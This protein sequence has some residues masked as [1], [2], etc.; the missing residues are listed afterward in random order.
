MA[1]FHVLKKLAPS[2]LITP[3]VRF[4]FENVSSIQHYPLY[5]IFRGANVYTLKLPIHSSDK[6]LN[7]W[8]MME[9]QGKLVQSRP[10]FK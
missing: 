9:N 2:Y 7:N 6:E 1:S 4:D 10:K 8:P 5:M 3:H